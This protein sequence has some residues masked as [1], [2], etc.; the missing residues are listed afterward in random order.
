M[1][2]SKQIELLI[3]A[4][5]QALKNKE[6][7]VASAYTYAIA[8]AEK[9]KRAVCHPILAPYRSFAPTQCS[10]CD[11]KWLSGVPNYCSGCGAEVRKEES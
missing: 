5:T 2:Q 9:S 7:Q 8:L 4:E 6:W 10:N 11:C 1:K 3:E